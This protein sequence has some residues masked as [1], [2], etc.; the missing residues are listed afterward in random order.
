MIV[1]D[2]S[3]ED[4]EPNLAP[5]VTKKS[6]FIDDEAEDSNDSDAADRDSDDDEKEGSEDEN[7]YQKDGFV[8]GE[9]E[10][11]EEELQRKRQ[12]AKRRRAGELIDSD[13]DDDDDEE[14]DDDDDNLQKYKQ[15]KKK[16][17]KKSKKHRRLRK[18]GA[19]DELD[20]DDLAL[21][22]EQQSGNN[23]NIVASDAQELEKGLFDE[24]D[25]DNL[26]QG[27]GDT[28]TA[29]SSSRSKSG[30]NHSKKSSTSNRLAVDR[31]DEDGLDDFI[32][33]DLDDDDR[34]GGGKS[35][36]GSS[37]RM[38]SEMQLNE[39]SEIFGEDYLDFTADDH[40]L[41]DDTSSDNDDDAS[42]AGSD[43]SD[44]DEEERAAARL[45][46]KKKKKLHTLAALKA[47]FEPAQLMEHFLS[48]RDEFLRKTDAPERYLVHY[49][50]KNI[51]VSLSS[52]LEK[53]KEEEEE[54]TLDVDG[55]RPCAEFICRQLFESNMSASNSTSYINLSQEDRNT[56]LYTTERI[57]SITYA[58]QHLHNCEPGFLANY[59]KDYFTCEDVRLRL[60]D[61]LDALVGYNEHMLLCEKLVVKLR[62]LAHLSKQAASAAKVNEEAMDVDSSSAATA[63]VDSIRKELEECEAKLRDV[64]VEQDLFGDP[65]EEVVHLKKRVEELQISLSSALDTNAALSKSGEDGNDTNSNVN[66]GSRNDEDWMRTRGL[67]HSYYIELYDT[68]HFQPEDYH[69]MYEYIRLLNEG[70]YLTYIDFTLI[71]QFKQNYTYLLTP[72]PL[73]YFEFLC[74]HVL[75]R[76]YFNRKPSYCQSTRFSQ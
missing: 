20:D 19:L 31:Y 6:N 32:E 67:L 53:K 11:E 10:L 50:D 22:R 13:D 36:S 15:R 3:D 29:A 33:D 61:V 75:K 8:V 52:S 24:D 54:D 66:T 56:Q 48:E 39:A 62:A 49:R 72:F 51:R 27:Y 1:D 45:A 47:K 38:V 9:E 30:K 16:K 41:E 57:S 18:K 71:A 44:V 23:Q 42:S 28:T 74:F 68:S 35:G 12:R 2:S 34:G 7:E 59:R 60:W 55:L 46:K 65:D 73:L 64:D 25:E 14:S 69:V 17:K 40:D 43:L 70:T 63:K 58:V 21:I 5:A 37:S 4:G 76:K 26:D